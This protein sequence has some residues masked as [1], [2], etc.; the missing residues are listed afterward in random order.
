MANVI[1]GKMKTAFEIVKRIYQETALLMQTV[2]GF[3]KPEFECPFGSSGIWDF[4]YRYDAGENWLVKSVSRCWQN[5]KNSMRAALI[6][7]EFL[8]ELEWSNDPEAGPIVTAM[9]LRLRKR[10]KKNDWEFWWRD[11]CARDSAI[12]NIDPSRAPLYRSVLLEGVERNCAEKLE[13]IDNFWL[14]LTILED[15]EMVRNLLVQPLKD[16]S[17]NGI[18]EVILP[19]QERYLR[20]RSTN[21]LDFQPRFKAA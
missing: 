14:P 5:S 16:I 11:D 20:L 21:E 15:R 4:S 1:A 19:D 2:E 18:A 6:S 3:M 12:F 7:V 9:S 17:K 13:G 10:I 8:P